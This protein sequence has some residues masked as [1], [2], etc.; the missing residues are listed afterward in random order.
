VRGRLAGIPARVTLPTGA[1]RAVPT[2]A[3]ALAELDIEEW[4]HLHRAERGRL[5]GFWRPKELD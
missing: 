3:L 5:V 4:D 2:A 1:L